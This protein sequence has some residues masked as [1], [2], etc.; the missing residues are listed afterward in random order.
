MLLK[1]RHFKR[2]DFF[3]T[4]CGRRVA[5]LIGISGGGLIDRL[6]ACS[7]G[8]ARRGGRERRQVEERMWGANAA[9]NGDWTRAI[10]VVGVGGDWG[11]CFRH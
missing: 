6:F 1:L 10:S 5:L 7:P 3:F 11:G 8:S 9:Q 2:M 4:L